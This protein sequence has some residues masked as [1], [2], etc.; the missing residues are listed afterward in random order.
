MNIS[1]RCILVTILALA[2]IA[3]LPGLLSAVSVLSAFGPA[4]VVSEVDALTS[5]E[6]LWANVPDLVSV[7]CKEQ[8]N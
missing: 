8:G 5:A 4:C 6:T 3:F 1:L 2:V 7:V